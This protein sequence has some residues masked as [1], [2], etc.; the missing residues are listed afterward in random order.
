MM[1]KNGEERTKDRSID[2]STHRSID[3]S[4]ARSMDIDGSMDRW[5][6]DVQKVEAVNHRTSTID[7]KVRNSLLADDSWLKRSATT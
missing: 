6:G 4:F 7:R 5:M 2:R 1:N 3:R